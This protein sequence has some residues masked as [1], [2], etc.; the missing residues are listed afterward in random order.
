MIIIV[1]FTNIITTM[2]VTVSMSINLEIYYI[3]TFK[4]FTINKLDY[5]PDLRFE[6]SLSSHGFGQHVYC[7]MLFNWDAP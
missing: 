3:T 1:R 2:V 4:L 6:L 5:I 7:S